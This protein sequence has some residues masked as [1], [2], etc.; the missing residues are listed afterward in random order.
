MRR[1]TGRL[2]PW[3]ALVLAGAIVV[4]PIAA[5]I[6]NVEAALA[7]LVVGL[8]VTAW[9]ARDIA[10]HADP[11]RAAALRRLAAMLVLLAVLGAVLLAARALL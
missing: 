2:P 7:V 3:Q 10:G 11:E 4:A 1:V 9:M 8:L 5:L 6:V